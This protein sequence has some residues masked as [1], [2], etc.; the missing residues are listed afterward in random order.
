MVVMQ[1]N[2]PNGP[3]A[4]QNPPVVQWSHC[5]Y[6]SLDQRGQKPGDLYNPETSAQV[7]G[8]LGRRQLMFWE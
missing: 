7:L 5:K 2:V 8:G 4:P 6:Y 3:Q 1:L